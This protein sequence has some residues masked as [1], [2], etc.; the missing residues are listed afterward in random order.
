MSNDSKILKKIKEKNFKIFEKHRWVTKTN[1]LSI[2]EVVRKLY[3]N[4]FFL[5]T[6][7]LDSFQSTK[8]VYCENKIHSNT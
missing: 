7:F 2:D 8:Q 3:K 6:E 5:A 4:I 1:G